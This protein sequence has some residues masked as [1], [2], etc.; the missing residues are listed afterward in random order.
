MPSNSYLI[1]VSIEPNVYNLVDSK[2]RKLF[3]IFVCFALTAN[4]KGIEVSHAI[5]I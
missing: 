5:L 2:A 3:F 1:D 4:E